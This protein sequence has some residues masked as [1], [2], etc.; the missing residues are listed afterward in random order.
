MQFPCA[1][2]AA[3]D[4][5]QS[6]RGSDSPNFP[7]WRFRALLRSA[8]PCSGAEATLG[9]RHVYILPTK[10]GL[11]LSGLVFVMLVSSL[12]YASNLGFL[13][14]FLLTGIGLVSMLHTW[15]NLLGLRVR[16]GRADPVFADQDAWF[17]IELE[18]PRRQPRPGIEVS[19]GAGEPAL[20]DLPGQ[21]R[22][23]VRLRIA[24]NRRGPLPL[25]RLTLATRYPMG[26]LRAWGYVELP[27]QCL[28]YPRPAASGDLPTPPSGADGGQGE[29]GRGSED[30]LGL[31]GYRPG[32]S[33]RH[34]FWKAAA[35]GGALLTKEFGGSTG[36]ELWLDWDLLPPLD[37]EARL[38]LLCRWVLLAGEQQVCYGLRLPAL[39]LSPGQG[40]QHQHRCL[41]ALARF[42]E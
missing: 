41:A 21:S 25:G 10:Y 3:P 33:P 28:V 29:R 34:V 24:T 16:G 12:N 2:M 35:R 36:E 19:V 5:R 37:T 1:D 20:V 27:V 17:S 23:S 11:I 31:R 8:R 6:A 13:Y 26:W 4:A 18:N 40:E 7:P 30:F 22:E 32:D 14:T 15:R 9:Q 38:S 42:A 39:E